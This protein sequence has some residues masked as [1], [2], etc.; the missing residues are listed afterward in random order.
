VSDVKKNSPAEKAGFRVGDIIV[1][2]NGEKTVDD[3]TLMSAVDDA[4]TGD[5]VDLTV[6]RE[7]KKIDLKLKLEKH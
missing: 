2:A 7:R 3:A 6:I 1:A 4:K 5:T